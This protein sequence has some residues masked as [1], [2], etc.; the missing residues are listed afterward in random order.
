MFVTSSHCVCPPSASVSL[1]REE[2]NQTIPRQSTPTAWQALYADR[3]TCQVTSGRLQRFA[4]TP[5]PNK[6]IIQS[7]LP[8]L[9]SWPSLQENAVI[10]SHADLSFTVLLFNT[11]SAGNPLEHFSAE[12]AGQTSTVLPIITAVRY[13][14]V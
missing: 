8:P 5:S 12:E 1:S 13:H 9:V 7:A 11:D 14:D 10:P 4:T 6:H 2:H 3:Y